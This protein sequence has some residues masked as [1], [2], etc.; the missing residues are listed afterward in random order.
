MASSFGFHACDSLIL[1]QQISFSAA[2]WMW[3]S[4]SSQ[5][6]IL[7]FKRAALSPKPN[8]QDKEF[9]LITDYAA[10]VVHFWVQPVAVWSQRSTVQTWG[11][12]WSAGRGQ[13]LEKGDHCGVG[14][15]LKRC[16]STSTM[17]TSGLC[18]LQ[19]Q[20]RNLLSLTGQTSAWLQAWLDPRLKKYC[21]EPI[22]F[23]F[24]D[25]FLCYSWV[26]FL[27]RVLIRPLTALAL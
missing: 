19:Q 24:S 10:I 22:S 26:G 17:R 23:P 9:Y 12:V 4:P 7:Q 3:P 8:L 16:K 14:K 20:Q 6:N 2:L 18:P 11:S 21:S 1:L 15:F 25:L 13:F 27:L 5:F